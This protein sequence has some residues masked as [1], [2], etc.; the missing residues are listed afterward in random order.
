MGYHYFVLLRTKHFGFLH[1]SLKEYNKKAWI[2]ERNT[3]MDFGLDM[4]IGCHEQRKSSKREAR[5][6]VGHWWVLL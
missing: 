6:E 4:T 2:L 1:I 3:E 5:P